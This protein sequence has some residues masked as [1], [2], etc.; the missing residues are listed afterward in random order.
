MA[1]ATIPHSVEAEESVLG[2][3]LIDPDAILRVSE[4]LRPDD[5]YVAKNRYV[6][7]AMLALFEDRTAIDYVTLSER[8]DASKRLR[9]AGGDLHLA[10]LLNVVPSA[11]NVDSY[12]ERV[13]E[14]SVRRKLLRMASEAARL[15]YDETIPL[16]E[17]LGAVDRAALA[18]H[19]DRERGESRLRHVESVLGEVFDTLSDAA[20]GGGAAVLSTG[21]RDLDRILGGF[22]RGG[23]YIVAART[24]I[25]KTAFLLTLA[26]RIAGEDKRVAFFSLEMS[27]QDVG[28]RLLAMRGA[29]TLWELTTCNVKD[30][31]WPAIAEAIGT[32]S[33]LPLMIDDTPALSVEALRT[34]AVRLSLEDKLDIV[35]VDYLQLMRT[36]ARERGEQRYREIARVTQG[37]KALA[38]ELRV[39][40]IAA[41]QLGRNAEGT[42]PTLVDLRESGD[43]ENDADGVIFIH[44]ERDRSTSNAQI[45]VAKHR[46]GATGI[47][48]VYWIPERV[49]FGEVYEGVSQW[50][51]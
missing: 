31:Q 36:D 5:F 10:N 41:A 21:Y 38:K 27:A 9:A 30:W 19:N 39:P 37:L 1:R 25:G 33:E 26:A 4:I 8:L 43:I 45:I 12:A 50:S 18:L 16:D 15:G 13:K 2:A 23:L 48:D 17:V 14:L 47:V 7:E 22:R 46:H 42:V 35:F 51:N 11:L 34:K 28:D 6:Y 32:A 20:E 24:G 40:V 29:A 3:I 49:T 44:R